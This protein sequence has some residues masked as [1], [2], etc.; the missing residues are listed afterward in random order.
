MSKLLTVLESVKLS[1]EYLRKKGVQ[2]PR[3]N[4]ELLLA[5]IL[6]CKR[7]DL[8]LMFDR[9]LSENEIKKYREYLSRRANF[10][11]LQY[12]LG[13]VEFY[14]MSFKVTKDV[15]IPRP[16]TELLVG[17]II[18]SAKTINDKVKILDVGTGSGNIAIA[19]QKNLKNAEVCG[20]DVS[21][22]ALE[23]A[24]ENARLN[25]VGVEFKQADVFDENI[26]ELGKFDLIVSNPPYVAKE[27]ID[28]LQEEIKNYEPIIAVTDNADGYSFFRRIADISL[29]ILNP[30]GM[31]FFEISEGQEHEVENILN[32]RGFKNIKTIK[33]FNGLARIIKGEL[34]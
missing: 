4:A 33:D 27:K 3:A 9:P 15:L 5:D 2:E 1:E 34:G 25:S 29:K 17:E 20:A 30:N 28:S 19:L 31:L 32:E 16:E 18:T 23:V 24:R 8:Y 10:E 26:F 21:A 7:L 11:P 14:G 13:K 22:K 12:I 6:H